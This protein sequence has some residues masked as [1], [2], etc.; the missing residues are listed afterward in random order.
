MN[1]NIKILSNCL[2][3]LW[4]ISKEI[5]SENN[6][7]NNEINELIKNQILAKLFEILN[8]TLHKYNYIYLI[9]SFRKDENIFLLNKNDD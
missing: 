7:N 6:N 2:K 3:Y 8:G 9:H 1:E 4:K 5:D